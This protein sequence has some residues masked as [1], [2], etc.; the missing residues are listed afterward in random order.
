MS[1]KD[2][3]VRYVAHLAR[4]KLNDRE[5]QLFARQ[6]DEILGYVDKLKKL[7]VKDTPPTSHPLVLTNVFRQDEMKPSISNEM[8]LKNAPQKKGDFFVVP[9]IIEVENPP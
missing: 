7:D 8:V 2:D 1:I 5:V 4:I 3:V 6:L 9:R